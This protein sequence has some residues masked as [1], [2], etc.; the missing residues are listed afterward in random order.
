MPEQKSA[1]KRCQ[2]AQNKN[3]SDKGSSGDD[4]SALQDLVPVIE[5][6]QAEPD[7]LIVNQ[8]NK[9]E[10]KNDDAD[11][12]DQDVEYELELMRQAL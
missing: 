12:S 7:A 5:K 1:K 6:S 3:K 9:T 11:S 2:S 8:N 10:A 4:I